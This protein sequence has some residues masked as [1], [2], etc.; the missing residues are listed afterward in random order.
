M[1][2]G[3]SANDTARRTTA[4]PDGAAHQLPQAVPQDPQP[5]RPAGGDL[6]GDAARRIHLILL[7]IRRP[8]LV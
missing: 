8:A 7:I 3:V 2:A 4:Q 5:L 1:T 6:P